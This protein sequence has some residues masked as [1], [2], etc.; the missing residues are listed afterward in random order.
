MLQKVFV[1]RTL[2]LRKIKFIGLDMDHTLV[3]YNSQ[4]FEKLAHE[5]MLKK[6]VE[7]KITPLRSSK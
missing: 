7:Q 6:L 4:A 1:N 3:R 2:N 5:S